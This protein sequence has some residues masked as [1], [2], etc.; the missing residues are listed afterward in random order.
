[1]GESLLGPFQG[2]IETAQV[3]VG[4]RIFG[5]L[6][7][8]IFESGYTILILFVFQE[9]LTFEGHASRDPQNQDQ[10]Q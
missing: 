9:S 5:F 3:I 10:E 1:M 2:Q 8:H 4:L 6:L 7:D